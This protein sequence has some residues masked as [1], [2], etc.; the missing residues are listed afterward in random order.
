MRQ[1]LTESRGGRRNER[2]ELTLNAIL[3]IG[4]VAITYRAQPL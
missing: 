2:G 3:M 1:T 4:A